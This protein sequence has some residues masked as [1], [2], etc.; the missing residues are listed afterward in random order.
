MFE[1]VL[2]GGNAHARFRVNFIFATNVILVDGRFILSGSDDKHAGV[3]EIS[4]G[5]TRAG[6]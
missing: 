2:A 4:D 3:V 5:V 6:R 1:F